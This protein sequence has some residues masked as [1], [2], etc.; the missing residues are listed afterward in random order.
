MTE[1]A[2][3]AS[4]QGLVPN[5]STASD[6]ASDDTVGSDT[7]LGG[8]CGASALALAC[9]A[10]PSSPR[11]CAHWMPIRVSPDVPLSIKGKVAAARFFV[12]EVLPT[13]A[14][15]SARRALR[16]VTISSWSSDEAEGVLSCDQT[17]P[18]IAAT[19]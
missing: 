2:S 7:L 15:L 8:V 19:W 18:R 5:R 16:V 17:A 10:A 3:W 13:V 11:P 12:R 6:S 14:A 9:C 4:I 1:R